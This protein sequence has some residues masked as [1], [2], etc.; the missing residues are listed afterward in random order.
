MFS[1]TKNN[2]DEHEPCLRRAFELIWAL[3]AAIM[4][5]IYCAIIESEFNYRYIVF[6]TAAPLYEPDWM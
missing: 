3:E 6:G 4:M 1:G 2:K 5:M